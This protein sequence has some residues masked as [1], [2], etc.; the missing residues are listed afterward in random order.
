MI[1]SIG[2]SYQS[3]FHQYHDILQ[4]Q[5]DDIDIVATSLRIAHH[6]GLFFEM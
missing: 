5:A 3:I 2:G 6:Y 4:K 1:E